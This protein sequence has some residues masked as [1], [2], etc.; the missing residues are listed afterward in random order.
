MRAAE[1][2]SLGR[3]LA[4]AVRA[5]VV[6][7]AC[8]L[9]AGASAAPAPATPRGAASLYAGPGFDTCAAP[10]LTSLQSWLTS[11]YRAVGIYLGGVNRACPD[12]NLSSSWTANAVASGWALLPLFVGLQAPCVAQPGLALIDPSAPAS[13]GTAA[14]DEAAGRA[15]A[16][17]LSPGAPIYFDMEGYKT[18]SPTCTQTVQAFLGAWAARLR[19]LGYLAGVYGSAAST[20]RDLIPFAGSASGPDAVWIGHWN[21]QSGVFGDP[22]VP[23][24][25]WANHQRIHQYRG[26]HNETYAGITLNIDSNSVDAP[27]VASGG[28]TGATPAPALPR[29]GSIVTSDG[30]AT[31]NWPA[32]AFAA[33][34]ALS[35]IPV[36]LAAEVNGF[37]AGS[38]V[39]QVGATNVDGSPLTTFAA[40]ITITFRSAGPGL[41]P[42]FSS[43]SARW[44][45][46]PLRTS[47]TLPPGA[48]ADYVRAAD[49]SLTV[50]MRAPGSIGLLR[51]VAPP[52]APSALAG[53]FV[54]GSL[55][56]RW[57]ASADNSGSVVGYQITLNGRPLASASGSTPT[58]S[59][60]AFYPHATSSYRI[61]AQDSAGNSS[62]PSNTL[63]VR[64]SSRPR[65]LPQP[66]PDWAY[67][68]AAWQGAGRSGSRPAAPRSVP[69]WYWR[70]RAWRQMPF[71]VA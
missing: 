57:R 30:H 20:I 18:D 71:K 9:T 69:A 19:S 21:G 49:G 42:A 33:G 8:F 70:W 54:R 38:Q 36:T 46:L 7:V 66:I 67:Q 63:I 26:G 37:A 17:G 39:V 5:S 15:A 62:P 47:G 35:A 22:Y 1:T 6:L 40:P 31:V 13:E 2:A 28:V 53:R 48:T 60:R 32:N 50:T 27:V 11:L 41:V 59:V 51:D 12:G 64:P 14:A 68:L 24:A 25:D 65:G 44:H 58:A 23:D 16:F 61:V 43:A 45:P 29:A 56:L 4:A 10:P 52:T 3:M 55:R 34:T